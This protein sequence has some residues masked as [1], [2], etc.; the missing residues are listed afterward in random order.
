[1]KDAAIGLR[2]VSSKLADDAALYGGLAL[3][4]EF[5]DVNV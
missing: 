1:M 5:L 4:K 3:A 2:I